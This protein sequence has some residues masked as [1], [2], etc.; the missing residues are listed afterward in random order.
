MIYFAI[1][2]LTGDRERMGFSSLAIYPSHDLAQAK[3]ENS[4][5]QRVYPV[6]VEETPLGE[7]IAYT[8]DGEIWMTVGE[9]VS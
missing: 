2:S 6:K 4:I 1:M 3:I 7:K 8:L 9:V 5:W